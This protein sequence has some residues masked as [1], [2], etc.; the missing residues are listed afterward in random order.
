MRSQRRGARYANR[1]VFLISLFFIFVQKSSSSLKTPL[2]V[3]FKTAELEKEMKVFCKCSFCLSLNPKNLFRTNRE[4]RLLP[5][6]PTEGPR[7]TGSKAKYQVGDDVKINCTSALSKPA[8]NLKWFVSIYSL[9]FWT[10]FMAL[11]EH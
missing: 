10:S 11:C 8:A 5:V 1:T 4:Q 7:I 3:E 6:L 2:T 9:R